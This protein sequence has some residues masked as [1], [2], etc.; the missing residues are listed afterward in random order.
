MENTTLTP[1]VPSFLVRTRTGQKIHAQFNH[2][3]GRMHSSVTYCGVRAASP[4]YVAQLT[5]ATA[6]YFCSSC[7]SAAF[8]VA[9]SNMFAA[10]RV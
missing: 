6:P 1:M 7:C 9:L 4:V 8:P 5:I 10:F 2:F 3:D